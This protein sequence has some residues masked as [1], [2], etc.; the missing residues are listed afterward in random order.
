MGKEKLFTYGTL[1]DGDIGRA[2]F[3]G[4]PERFPDR[5][6][7]YAKTTT[8]L[9]GMSYPNIVPASGA[10]VEGDVVEV[11]R[12]TLSRVDGY[13]AE[14]YQRKKV[15]LESGISAWVYIRESS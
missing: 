15:R 7:G 10:I 2:L 13:E 9:Q 3:G 8:S 14:A 5:L 12:E 6:E 1:R 4:K 11:D